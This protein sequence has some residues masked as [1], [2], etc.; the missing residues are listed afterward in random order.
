MV[1]SRSVGAVMSAI[2][3]QYPEEFLEVPADPSSVVR[4]TDLRKLALSA[5]AK[6]AGYDAPDDKAEECFGVWI[7]ARHDVEHLLY[8]GTLDLLRR[9]RERGLRLCAITN[10]NCDVM[11]VPC[12]A[13]LLDFCVNAERVGA[14]KRTGRPY[15]AAYSQAG[16]C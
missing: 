1:G 13:P 7:S 15:E 9:L 2:A 16:A 10:G 3:K 11:R 8:P 14:R 6:D 4:F 5:L 12:L